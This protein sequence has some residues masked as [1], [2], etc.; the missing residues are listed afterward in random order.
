MPGQARH[1]IVTVEQLFKS[2]EGHFPRLYVLIRNQGFQKLISRL[3]VDEVHHIHTAGLPHNGLGAFRP[4]WGRLD[5]LRAI[6]PHRVKVGAYSATVT[7]PHILRTVEL[8]LL[9]PTYV[10]IHLTSNRPNTMYATHE[11][12]K[13]ID[14]LSNYDC[15]L[16]KPYI[17]EAQ[18]RV[19]IFVDNKDLACRISNYL[20]SC[21]PKE[22]RKKNIVMHY[23]SQ[24]SE[25]YL[26][27]A[28]KCFTQINGPCR[29]MVATSGQSVVRCQSFFSCLLSG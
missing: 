15:F 4:A 17:L 26:M 13:N 3:N 28:H 5:E 6:L 16:M 14:E 12:K 18:P 8:K 1:L 25:E 10:F 11:V 20:D 19:L 27:F 2:R 7:A 23:H 24:M 21:L 22:L 29:I 9:R